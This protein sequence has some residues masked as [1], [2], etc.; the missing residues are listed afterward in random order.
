MSK[1]YPLFKKS[2]KKETF[3]E[4]IIGAIIIGTIVGLFYLIALPIKAISWLIAYIIFS[5]KPRYFSLMKYF[6]YLN[7]NNLQAELDDL[8]GKGVSHW[9]WQ[10]HGKQVINGEINNKKIMKEWC[11]VK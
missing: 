1:Q 4:G 7:E 8:H 6:D 2:G 5:K 11:E 10:L 9:A 3:G